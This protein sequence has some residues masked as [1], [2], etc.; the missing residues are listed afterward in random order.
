MSK[1]E[2]EKQLPQSELEIVF[3]DHK[4]TIK[5]PNSGQ[6]IDI[7][8]LKSNLSGGSYKNLFGST[9]SAQWA[10]YYI[11]TVATF[12][13]LVPKII[14]DLNTDSILNLSMTD[15]IPLVKEF[16]DKFLPWYNEWL[17]LLT[18]LGEGE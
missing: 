9:I 6:F 11:D 12:N 5:F 4:Y 14:E 1:K 15:S 13:V 3:K 17:T 16:K 18:G 8:L 2:T 7:E 10:R